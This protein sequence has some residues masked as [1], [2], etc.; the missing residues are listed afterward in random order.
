MR[1]ATLAVA[2]HGLAL[3]IKLD[4]QKQLGT[5]V[6]H[7]QL[8]TGLLPMLTSACQLRMSDSSE[9]KNNR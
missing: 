1:G 5:S 6:P 7:D 8:L 4:R 2:P 3:T 9:R